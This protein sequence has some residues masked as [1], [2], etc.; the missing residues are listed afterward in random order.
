ML[1]YSCSCNENKEK[2]NIVYDEIDYPKI[3]NNFSTQQFSKYVDK[4]IYASF[5][6]SVGDINLLSVPIAFSDYP[7][8]NEEENLVISNTNEKFLYNFK[9]LS[10]NKDTC[11]I[12]FFS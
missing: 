2:E 7:V 4:H 5:T 10:L 12:A 6:P 11:K 1:L 8:T 9:I 3:K